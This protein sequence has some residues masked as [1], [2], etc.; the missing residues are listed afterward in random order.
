MRAIL[1][2]GNRGVANRVE[3]IDASPDWLVRENV[4]SRSPHPLLILFLAIA[5]VTP[6]AAQHVA[7]STGEVRVE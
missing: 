3:S 2:D 1:A 7:R 4:M 6:L 5:A